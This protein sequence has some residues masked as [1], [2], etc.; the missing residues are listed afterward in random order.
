LLETRLRDRL[1]TV[2]QR[3]QQSTTL[4]TPEH[5][6][7]RLIETTGRQAE[8][9]EQNTLRMASHINSA[10]DT[11]TTSVTGHIS[12]AIMNKL[13]SRL[14]Q[15]LN[16]AEQQFLRSIQQLADESAAAGRGFKKEIETSAHQFAGGVAPA[17]QSFAE[18]IIA[19]AGR[20]DESR[21]QFEDT[22]INED[23]AFTRAFVDAGETFKRRVADS[24]AQ[25]NKALEQGGRE[26]THKLA[27]AGGDFR[28]VVD[29]AGRDFKQQSLPLLDDLTTLKTDIAQLCKTIAGMSSSFNERMQQAVD[30]FETI[31]GE[32]HQVNLNLRHLNK[33]EKALNNAKD[34]LTTSSFSLNA[35]IQKMESVVTRIDQLASF[36][37]DS[38]QDVRQFQEAL[39]RLTTTLGKLESLAKL[40]LNRE[41]RQL[42]KAS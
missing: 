24:A 8:S 9:F 21:R 29:L 16:Q 2:C 28:D 38:S 31:H 5:L 13:E 11:M 18:Q 41:T 20:I 6:L 34:S 37:T 23:G 12:D 27:G 35:L 33:V 14:T 30:R 15:V 10:I 17:G 7:V 26:W 39:E 36:K 3:L 4:Y 40:R 19:S 42:E 1:A 32:L 25:F 22:I